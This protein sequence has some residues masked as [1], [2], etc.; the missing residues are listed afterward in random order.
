MISDEPQ[1]LTRSPAA[2]QLSLNANPPNLA[3][4][5]STPAPALTVPDELR[6]RPARA[7]TVDEAA[8]P[9]AAHASPSHAR[10]ALSDPHPT[11][12]QM[13][14]RMTT[15]LFTPEVPVAPAPGYVQSLKAAV[16]SSWV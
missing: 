4:N 15:S 6:R 8:N 5:P 3:S 13:I 2:S 14:R 16:F 9:A 11:R 12:A 10:R 7:V 1:P